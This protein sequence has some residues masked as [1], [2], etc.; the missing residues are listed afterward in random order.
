MMNPIFS[1]ICA[2]GI[3]GMCFCSA[4]AEDVSIPDRGTPAQPESAETQYQAGVD[5]LSGKAG[6]VDNKKAFEHFKSAADAGHALAQAR[7]AICYANGRGVAKDK[8]EANRLAQN[9]WQA[10]EVDAQNNNADAQRCFGSLYRDGIG[11][12]Q[13]YQEAMNWFRKAAALG[14]SDAMFTIGG[15]YYEG[16]GVKKN[17]QEAMNWFRKAADGG[18]ATSMLAIGLLHYEGEGVKQDYKE[19]MNWYRKAADL[20]NADAMCSIGSLYEDGDGVEQDYKE[21]MNWYRKAADSGKTDAMCSI[22]SLYEEGNGVEQDYK[23]AMNWY[24]KAADLGNADA[25]GSIG[26]FYHEG[27]GVEQDCH[28]AMTWYRKAAD[29][30]DAKGM[31]AVGLLYYKGDGVEQ[32]YQQAM[33][34]YRKAADLGNTKG[35]IAI[36]LLYYK[37][38]GVKQ[39][40]QEAMNWYRKAADLGDDDAK[41]KAD[42]LNKNIDQKAMIHDMATRWYNWAGILALGA[43]VFIWR[44]VTKL[45]P[46]PAEARAK[47][48][49]ADDLQKKA[50]K[51]G[52]LV[53][54]PDSNSNK[55]MK[56]ET[57]EKTNTMTGAHRLSVFIGLFCSVLW[58]GFAFLESHGFANIQSIDGWLVFGLGI[59]VFFFLPF[60]LIRGIAWVCHGFRHNKPMQ[61]T[62]RKESETVEGQKMK[63][64]I[65]QYTG[66]L[67]IAVAIVIAAIIT[68]VAVIHHDAALRSHDTTLELIESSQSIDRLNE[69]NPVFQHHSR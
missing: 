54:L 67:I 9:S 64:M 58:I 47:N 48:E 45:T 53:P 35:M 3:A 22:A 28:E 14:D 43:L 50:E 29:L 51:A 66:S 38:E 7:L 69:R 8:A 62:P 5:F 52:R 30:G 16:N 46:R 60:G 40:Y 24:R 49:A 55:D 32:D 15:L 34:W 37:G 4:F 33:T 10:V 44:K 42:E 59:A 2:A 65:K 13:D 18:H 41:A 31:I 21:A 36:G 6:K 20:G 17:Y 27:E 1:S 23:E 25:M 68:L 19:A 56:I 61:S 12:K 26:V 57:S 63:P 11:V 39:D